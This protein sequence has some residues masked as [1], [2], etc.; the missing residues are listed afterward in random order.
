MIRKQHN[1]KHRVKLEMSIL[2]QTIKESKPAVQVEVTEY[3]RLD[4]PDIGSKSGVV[5]STR[6]FRLWFEQ[7][8]GGVAPFSLVVF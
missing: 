6:L 5:A 2:N 4:V 7:T 3:C 1:T 8:S